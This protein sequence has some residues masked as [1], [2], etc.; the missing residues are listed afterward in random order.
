MVEHVEEKV[1][2][3]GVVY[4]S[5]LIRVDGGDHGVDLAGFERELTDTEGLEHVLHL[6]HVQDP[7][8]VLVRLLERLG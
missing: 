1:H 3:L 7:V 5:I 4:G 2:E 8:A 6:V